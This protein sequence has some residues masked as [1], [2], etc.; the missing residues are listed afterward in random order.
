MKSPSIL[1]SIVAAVTM[2]QTGAMAQVV[3]LDQGPHWTAA[4]Q[5]LFYSVDQG[6]LVMPLSWM[7]ALRQ[8]NGELFL[9]DSL[10]RYGYIANATSD[11]N[12]QG[13]PVGFVVS[14][15]T[16][17]T[18]YF[19][20]TCAACHTREIN[21]N[22]INYRADGG[23]AF[24]DAYAFFG[25]M[26]QAVNHLLSSPLA[27]VQFQQA[28]GTPPKQLRIQLQQWYDLEN[29][30]MGSALPAQ[31][32]GIA[33]M[34]A[35]N[36]ALN[37]STGGDI[38]TSPNF[39][40]PE[41]IATAD[42]PVRYPFLWN[43]YRQDLTQ[44]AGET[45]NG[46]VPLA[47]ARNASEVEGVFGV[48]HPVGEDHTDFLSDNSLNYAGL[49]VIGELTPKIGPPKWPWQVDYAKA[50]LGSEIFS[51]SCA[52]CHGV[53][54]GI[55]RLP[56]TD[57]WATRIVN[58]GTDTKY[59]TSI[60][61]VA[62]SSGLLGG[63][64]FPPVTGSVVGSS[65][66]SSLFLSTMLNKSALFQLNSIYKNELNIQAP[67]LI[68][69]GYEARVLHGIWAAAPYLH[70]GSV[71]TLTELLKNPLERVAS[72]QV[73]PNYDIENVG[74]AAVQPGGSA[75]VFTATGGG[76]NLGS[77][78]SNAGHNFGT[79]LS[80]FA[81]DALLEY[82]K[83]A[84]MCFEDANADGNVDGA[85]LGIFLGQWGTCSPVACQ[86]D[87]NSDGAVDGVDLAM[88][89]VKWGPCTN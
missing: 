58:V 61:R 40:I 24:S 55:P 12:P 78:N 48:I 74:L 79:S 75:S 27:F 43:A 10:A 53:A 4:E 38:G 54:P 14:T 66:V 19:S 32:W 69:G 72:F 35:I 5:N 25:D 89:L 62:P 15:H 18:P 45:V 31:T 52:S 2:V 50:R 26:I 22:G 1:L 84:G 86:C 6:S 81:K 21:V 36:S 73:G 67:A 87:F 49:Q 88:L 11:L 64:V 13:L 44:W 39:L 42:V 77:G 70:N 51:K 33:R 34:D 16:T 7:Q 3:R 63:M 60:A 41:N 20:M 85:D 56:V 82:L 83:I 29:T 30:V 23:P 76:A 47:F 80:P 46:N 57:T 8:P 68:T 28:V 37:R 9:Q 65:N 71:P 17:S 59:H